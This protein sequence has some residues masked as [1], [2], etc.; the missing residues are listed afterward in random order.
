MNSNLFD[1]LKIRMS[2]FD[3]LSIFLI[4]CGG[5]GS[6][7]VPEMAQAVSLIQS[8]PWPLKQLVFYLVDHD[9]VEA[10]NLTRQHFVMSDLGKYKAQVLAERY[11]AAYGIPIMYSLSMIDATSHVTDLLY[12]VPVSGDGQHDGL[13][14]FITAVDNHA[15]RRIVSEALCGSAGQLVRRRH[16]KDFFLWIDIANEA[17]AGHVSIGSLESN[18]NGPKI[19]PFVTEVFP[20]ILEHKQRPS[21]LPCGFGGIQDLNV[22][23]MAAGY[24]MSY[25]RAVLKAN[26]TTSS[27]MFELPNYHL[28]EFCVAPPAATV[29]F[30]TI[31]H[32]RKYYWHISR[33]ENMRQMAEQ[34]NWG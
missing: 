13:I 26:D 2:T 25:I 3:Y 4:G 11:A 27:Q 23:A 22:N 14:L 17:L 8:S 19:L 12:S 28:I 15:T 9:R 30:N 1:Y 34:A 29:R 20:E 5:T 6:K 24:A 16:F 31:E 7:L 10:H 32:Y 33:M 21:E 18:F